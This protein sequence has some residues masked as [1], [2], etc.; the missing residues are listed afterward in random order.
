[1]TTIING[2]IFDGLSKIENG[3][4]D[5]IF[6]DPPYNLKKQY[7]D[8]ISDKWETDDQYI[9]WV[10]KWLDLAI[11]KLSPHGSLY[12]MN[13]TQNMPYI[14]I[15]LR[16]K[17][18]VKSRI[19]WSYDSSGVQAKKHF[20]SL[21]EPMLFCT[22]HKTKYTF[23]SGDILVPAKTGGERNL[24]DYR[25]NPPEKYN[26]FKVPGNVWDFSRVRYRMK[27][28]VEHPSQKPEKLL[29]RIVKASSNEN[30]VVL[31]LFAGTF[32]LGM[33][34]QRLN[35]HY[36]GI[37]LSESYCKSGSERLN[38]SDITIL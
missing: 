4:A 17:I 10:Y 15:Y 33:V 25:K 19:V 1:M 24:T 13:T 9:I 21:Y 3:S 37:E 18:C 27:E 11:D 16:E 30:D 2:D 5:L 34:S 8:E 28:Y 38:T 36:I 7:A 31:D 20:G 35:R 14:D 6:I 23:N 29:E 26:S 22:K 32:S 12:I